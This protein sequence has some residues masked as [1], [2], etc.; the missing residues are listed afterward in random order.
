[1]LAAQTAHRQTQRLYKKT[2]FFFLSVSLC[3]SRACLG[4]IIVFKLKKAQKWRFLT[5][6]IAFAFASCTQTQKNAFNPS[7][8]LNPQFVPVF[9]PSLSW[10]HDLLFSGVK[11]NGIA[12]KRRRFSR[13]PCR[14][15]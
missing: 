5:L 10:Q 12:K 4:K 13:A 11:L 15:R 7:S 1:V 2:P 8:F 3:L 6:A 14:P 9:V